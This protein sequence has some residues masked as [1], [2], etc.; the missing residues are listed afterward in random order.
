MKITRMAV[1]AALLGSIGL[2]AE[3][4]ELEK[5]VPEAKGYELIVKFNPLRWRAEK[6]Q[7]DRTKEL[8]GDLQR[9]GYLV[10]L[11]AK[12]GA[13]SWVFA[14]M[15][16]FTKDP[17]LLV[18]PTPKSEVFQQY[19]TNLEV[20]GN[21]EGVKTGRF[22]KGNIE[23]WGLNYGGGNAKKIPGATNKFDFG[24]SVDNK[25]GYGSLQVHNYL[26]KQTVFAFNNFNAGANCDLGIGNNPDAQG[27]PDWTFSKAGSKYQ[28]AEIYVVGKFAPAAGK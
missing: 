9:I 15:D 26:E 22:E 3:V 11:T 28:S 23:I 24:D 21:V 6:Y 25:G 5:L 13:Q 17:A 12:D 7:V 20:A 18:V 1:F 14:S 10:K 4:P 16:A 27:H 8:S 19:V 2:Q